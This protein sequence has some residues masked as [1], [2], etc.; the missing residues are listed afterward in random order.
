MKRAIHIFPPLHSAEKI[1][2]IRNVYD[3]LSD[4]IPPHITLV[5]PFKSCIP[6][7]AILDHVESV[8]RH[9]SP[10][11]LTL[12]DITGS[13][14]EYLFLNVKK[15]NDFLIQLHDELY[16]GILAP[17]RDYHFTYTP[18]IT[19]GRPVNK[20]ECIRAV[21]RY[22]D[23]GEIYHTV[24]KEIVVEEIGANDVST[25]IGRLPLNTKRF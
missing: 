2:Q 14:G 18:H 20:G 19:L 5:F 4:K 13:G 9:T 8:A 16:K 6:Q 21:E 11:K 3:P 22:K 15:G 24:V 25:V 12:R 7:N 23:W 10:F 17:F 1:Q